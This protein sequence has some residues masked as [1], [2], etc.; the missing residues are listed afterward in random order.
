[1]TAARAY[2]R[3]SGGIFALL[4]CAHVARVFL[5]GAYVLREPLFVA[6]SLI[7]LGMT[8]WAI[9]LLRP[10]ACPPENRA[11]HESRASR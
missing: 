7:A 11:G 8:L 6:T 3:I 5:D 1:M 4:L 9:R 10:P 2:V